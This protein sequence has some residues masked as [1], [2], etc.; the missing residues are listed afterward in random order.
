MNAINQ[1]PEMNDS[2]QVIQNEDGTFT[3]EWDPCDSRWSVLNGKT[4]EEISAMIQEA[5]QE[6]LKTHDN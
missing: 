5:I 3:I 4:S 2:L 6:E 1:N